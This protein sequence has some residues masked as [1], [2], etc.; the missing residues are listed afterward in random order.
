M[1]FIS[2][3]YNSQSLRYLLLTA[4]LQWISYMH[5]CLYGLHLREQLTLEICPA[6]LGTFYIGYNNF[7]IRRNKTNYSKILNVFRLL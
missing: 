6:I 2:C 4:P 3:K 1:Y 5:I 7:K